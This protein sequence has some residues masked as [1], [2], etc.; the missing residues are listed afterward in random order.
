MTETYNTLDVDA[1][2]LA[3]GGARTIL[4]T[5]SER[6]EID[7]AISFDKKLAELEKLG[8]IGKTEKEHLRFSPTRVA[9][10][11]TVDGSRR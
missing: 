3:A 11:F 1:R 6:L 7:Q 4:D 10:L 8:A 9:P 2:V 5:A